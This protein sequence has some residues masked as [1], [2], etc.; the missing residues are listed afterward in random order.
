MI[1]AQIKAINRK[2]VFDYMRTRS[3]RDGEDTSKAEISKQTGISAPTMTKM[4][5]FFLDH[6]L[7][8]EGEESSISVGRPAQMLKVKPDS[9]YAVGFLLEGIY[10]YIGVVDILGNI[11]Y[12]KVLKMEPDLLKVLDQIKNCLLPAFLKESGIPREKL[13]G[14]GMAMPVSYSTKK[15][16]VSNGPLVK[17]AEEVYIGEYLEELERKYHVPVIFDNDAN[18]EC[19]GVGRKLSLFAEQED[20]LLLSL[21]T[22]VGAAVMLDGKLRRGYHEKCGEIWPYILSCDQEQEMSWENV[23]EN[24]LC[25]SKIFEKHHITYEDI[26]KELDK[27]SKKQIV[28]EIARKIAAVIHN[29]N[30]LLDCR[31]LVICGYA[32]VLLGDL[33][34]DQVKYYLK[35]LSPDGQTPRLRAESPFSGVSGIA[36]L[37]IEEEI[38][39]IL[40]K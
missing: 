2:A 25:L 16:T 20:L 7:V 3:L 34:L 4:A 33:F 15:K 27:E 23:L 32:V 28:E 8:E 26:E 22:G 13:V 9:M 38:Q 40:E 14:I 35:K 10:L 31:D 29:L 19:L 5:E 39:R 21:G 36:G 30:S 12:R 24:Q 11:I 18:A 1:A 37:W 17:I 6:G